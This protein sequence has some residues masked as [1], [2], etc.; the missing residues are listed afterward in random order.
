MEKLV[1]LEM[2]NGTRKLVYINANDIYN[3]RERSRR[4]VMFKK[5]FP[6]FSVQKERYVAFQ[7]Y[8]QF[9]ATHKPDLFDARYKVRCTIAQFAK[10]V[11]I[12]YTSF[13][14]ARVEQDFCS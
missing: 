12:E 3:I 8:T 6:F 14:I 5:S 2:L 13:D 11:G 10:L 9:P 1:E 4:I 7:C